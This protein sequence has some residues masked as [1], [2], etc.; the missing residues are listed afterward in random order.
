MTR[1]DAAPLPDAPH[2]PPTTPPG[3]DAPRLG[4]VLT[5]GG[6]RAAYQVGALQAIAQLQR[7]HL[8]GRPASPFGIITGTSAG[9]VNAAALACGADDFSTAV[10]RI[11]RVWRNFRTQ[12]VYRADAL[13]MLDAMGRM[14]LLLGIGQLLARWLRIRPRSLLDIAPLAELLADV[15]PL[16]RLQQMMADGH[17]QALAVSA[18]SYSSGQHF[19]FYDSSTPQT[20]W[21]RSQRIAMPTAIGHE[22]LLASS[23]IPFV[24]PARPLRVGG[25]TEYFGDGS[26]RQ[27]APL[28]P[29]IH[30]GADRIL[31]IGAGRP[32]RASIASG[33]SVEH[34]Y[35]TLAQVAGHALSSIFLDSLSSD[36]ER[37]NRV[38]KTLA[39]IE[40]KRRE[41]TM[42][43]PVQLLLIAPS[44]RLDRIA[45][46]YVDA[47]PGA[48][49]RLFG[50]H[51]RSGGN[52]RDGGNGNGS[53]GDVR[54]AALASYL[55][56]D[57]GY[58]RELMA[59]GRADVRARREELLA[60]FDWHDTC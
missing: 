46:R 11:A 35:P 2:A 10:R 27:S 56:F 3:A 42:L 21:V 13:G 1:P 29:A 33:D 12:Q 23:A 50:V 45:L 5:G 49:Q 4:L 48:V 32:H 22:H 58:T 40:P 44:Q 54:G 57:Q 30:L 28:A 52:G 19:T 41:Q 36:V 26:M 38:N 8:R 20:P 43:R 39:L 18:S 24:F 7:Q 31:A 60:F 15:V 16:H 37:L 47:L 25:H 34:G 17:L 9:A 59:L 51:D 55:L 53:E 14:R 6:A